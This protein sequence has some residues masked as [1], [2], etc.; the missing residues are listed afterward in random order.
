MNKKTEN[1]NQGLSGILFFSVLKKAQSSDLVDAELPV[2]LND[3]QEK[4]DKV[5]RSGPKTIRIRS[6]R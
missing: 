5:I 2:F 1:E 4:G 6:V 3:G